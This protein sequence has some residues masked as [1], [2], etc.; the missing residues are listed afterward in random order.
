MRLACIRK[1]FFVCTIVAT[2]ICQIGN[3]SAEKKA[4]VSTTDD[5]KQKITL[6][7]PAKRIISLAPHAT[8]LLFA[9]GAGA[10]IVGV[11]EYSDYPEQAKKITSVGN[12]FCLLWIIAIFAYTNNLRASAY[13]K[14]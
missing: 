7:K 2:T 12:V 8:E 11:S 4:A 5:S 9:V 14:Q 6:D 10:Q 13:R 3:A 1:V